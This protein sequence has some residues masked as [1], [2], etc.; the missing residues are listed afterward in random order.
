M[1]RDADKLSFFVL[2]GNATGVCIYEVDGVKTALIKARTNRDILFTS[3]RT[4]HANFSSEEPKMK[5]WSSI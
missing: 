2:K 1:R 4:P 3:L 5:Y